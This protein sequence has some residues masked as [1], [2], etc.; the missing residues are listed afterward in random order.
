MAD[1][2]QSGTIATLH[3]L[4]E[5]SLESLEAELASWGSDR[6]M[7]LIIPCLATEMNGPALRG[8]ISELSS[9]PY[10]T[11]VIIGLDHANRNDFTRAREL[12]AP[13][14]QHHRIVWN[15]SP[16]L[17]SI[18]TG[19]RDHGLAPTEAGKGRNVWW[20]LGYFLASGRARSVALHDADILTYD[21]SLV[22]RLHYPIAHPTFGYA[23]AKGYYCRAA[24]DGG[25]LNGRVT[26]LFVAPL[27]RALSLTFG[28]S[29]YLDF[30][31]SFRYP[32][33][34]EC[35]MDRSVAGTIRIPSDWGLEI[36]VLGEVFR[37]H[38]TA[39]VC[40]VDVADVYDHKHQELSPDDASAGLHRMSVDIAKS[41]FKKLASSGV[42]LTSESFRTLEA[43]FFRS[44]LDLIDSYNADA[45][46]NGIPYDR[47]EEE[48]TADVFA[49]AIIRAG[50]DY[51]DDPMES[52]FIPSWSRVDSDLPDLAENLAK[53]V[54]ADN[55]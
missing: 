29:D 51:L 50:D 18:E 45:T 5:R 7:S 22:A 14:P 9:V 13:L 40:Q 48:E 41:M 49:H 2:S 47:Q 4:G 11:E 37:R 16:R 54:E 42:V 52:P 27:L 44:A 24:S 20:C 38:N 26:R 6:P 30:I 10:L 3:H 25:R 39:R 36:G 32:L 43:A 8:I 28:R 12:F 55:A 23:F 1:F 15:D 19:L 53:A 21:R 33:A 35:A 34:G 31:D 17:R 46:L